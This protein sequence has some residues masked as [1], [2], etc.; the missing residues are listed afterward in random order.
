[1]LA[2]LAAS[3]CKV[4]CNP[5]LKTLSC[6]ALSRDAW[7]AMATIRERSVENKFDRIW[8]DHCLVLV[9]ALQTTDAFITIEISFHPRAKTRKFCS[10]QDI[11]PLW[12]KLKNQT[13]TTRNPRYTYLCTTVFPSTQSSLETTII[14]QLIFLV[15]PMS[16][17]NQLT[18][19]FSP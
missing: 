5:P 16:I 18:F 4:C 8:L 6:L 9:C 12:Q 14:C 7:L 2:S 1:M 11:S 17:T 19:Y 10:T 3:A 13:A 15:T